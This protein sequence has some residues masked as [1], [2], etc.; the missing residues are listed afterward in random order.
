MT[1]KRSVAAHVT[2]SKNLAK[3]ILLFV[4]MFACLFEEIKAGAR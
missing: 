1:R 3:E 4:L 2:E